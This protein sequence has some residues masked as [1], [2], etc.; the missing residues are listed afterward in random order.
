MKPMTPAILS[1]KKAG[2]AFTVH[3][4]EHDPS[5]PSYGLEA[6]E[7]LGAAPERIFKTLI[8][9][10]GAELVVGIVP[11]E[12]MLGLKHLAKAAGT[13]KAAMADTHQAERATGYVL[14]GISPLGQKK[15]LRTFIDASARNHP[16]IFV[17]AGRRGLE[18]ELSPEDLARLTNGTFAPLTA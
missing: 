3:E 2:I 11:V 10:A 16:T 13:K 1:A 15:R 6:A 4:Y 12:S 17:S 18:I 14:G 8:V 9:D 5:P 7:K